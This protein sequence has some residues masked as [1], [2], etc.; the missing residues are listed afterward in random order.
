M[1]MFMHTHYDNN[2]ILLTYRF[3]YASVVISNFSDYSYSLVLH[4]CHVVICLCGPCDN[5]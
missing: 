1:R 5:H 4:I 3:R 2:C